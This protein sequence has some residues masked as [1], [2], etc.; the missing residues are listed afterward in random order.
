ML[1]VR[2]QDVA[3]VQDHADVVHVVVAVP[4]DRHARAV[5]S[6]VG[7]VRIRRFITHD[8]AI[9]LD[10]SRDHHLGVLDVDD[11]LEASVSD[12]RVGEV[13]HL[14]DDLLGDVVGQQDVLL[15]MAESWA[16]V[17]PVRH[18]L[19]GIVLAADDG[20]LAGGGVVR[21]A[22]LVDA[23]AA[24][25]LAAHAVGA[26]GVARA[27]EVG[28]VAAHEVLVGLGGAHG[29]RHEHVVAAL[30]DGGPAGHG[31]RAAPQPG[32]RHRR[33]DRLRRAEHAAVL[34]A[35]R[36]LRQRA[37]RQLH[38]GDLCHG[39]SVWKDLLEVDALLPRA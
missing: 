39:Y 19:H 35:R 6:G 22:V 34:R 5:L 37:D 31:G 3:L 29:Q 33:V 36:Q 15:G 17:G 32:R 9:G 16:V 24:R 27:V 8:E 38:R 13:L 1:A 28:E 20:A 25:P 2:A 23:P 14:Q 11:A 7:F 26:R 30:R 12:L 4:H 21:A 18:Q 10:A